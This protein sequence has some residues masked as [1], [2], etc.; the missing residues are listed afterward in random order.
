MEKIT[1][2][3]F[4]ILKTFSLVPDKASGSYLPH[5]SIRQLKIADICTYKWQISPRFRKPES[6][7]NWHKKANRL[8]GILLSADTGPKNLTASLV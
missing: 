7:V 5:N 2:L 1:N 4:L 3:N 8:S 6:V